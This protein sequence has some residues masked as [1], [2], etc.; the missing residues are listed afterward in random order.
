MRDGGGTDSASLSISNNNNKHQ[1]GVVE[2]TV[3]VLVRLL[4]A[5]YSKHGL[6]V[7]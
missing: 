5:Y 2:R 3:L 4:E 1:S 6:V 7:D